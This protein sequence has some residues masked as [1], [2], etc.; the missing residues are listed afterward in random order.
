MNAAATTGG[1]SITYNPRW[2]GTVAPVVFSYDTGTRKFSVS[3][4][5]NTIAPAAADDPN[6]ITAMT[7]TGATQIRMNAYNS[8][9]TYATATPQP[10]QSGTSMNARIGFAMSYY[11]RGL[12]WGAGSLLGCATST[13]VPTQTDPIEADANPILLGAQNINVYLSIIG[14]SGLDSWSNRKNLLASIPIEVAPLN[15]NSYTTSSVEKPAVTLPTEIYEMRIELFD[16]RG[17]PFYQPPNY[18]TELVLSVYY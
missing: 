5:G 16:E 2:Y 18:N 7:T 14:G 17:T 15:I 8:S 13:G 9:N 6:V 10:T 3:L 11:A 4:A 12:W 1:D